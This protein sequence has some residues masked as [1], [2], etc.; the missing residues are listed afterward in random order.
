MN[1]RIATIEGSVDGIDV[2]YTLA[3]VEGK[4]NFYQLLTWTLGDKK[5]DYKDKMQGIVRSI[6]EIE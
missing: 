5:E 3:A 4:N 1:A 2:F 6:Q